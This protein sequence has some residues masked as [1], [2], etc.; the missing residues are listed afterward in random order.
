MPSPVWL[1]HKLARRLTSVRLQR[2]LPY[3][4]PDGKTQVGVEYKDGRPH[5]IHAIT[6]I[7]SQDKAEANGG[8]DLK[9]LQDDM[10]EYVI[11]PAFHDEEIMTDG[12]TKIF[13]NPEGPV[14]IG[15]PFVRR[16]L[17][18]MP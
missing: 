15:G 2:I 18:R 9:R 16:G 3:L 4:E 10:M 11:E 14:I 12:R 5:R 8:P 6:I 7:A 1:A 13:I 17:R